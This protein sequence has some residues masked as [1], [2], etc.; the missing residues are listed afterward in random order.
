MKPVSASLHN[1][2]WVFLRPVSHQVQRFF[3]G[4]DGTLEKVHE[5]R[6]VPQWV[7]KLREEQEKNGVIYVDSIGEVFEK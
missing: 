1:S 2:Q 6:E 4:E 3:P 5:S 7:E